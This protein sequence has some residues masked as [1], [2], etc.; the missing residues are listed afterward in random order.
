VQLAGDVDVRFERERGVEHGL[1]LFQ[2]DR[3]DRLVDAVRVRGGLL[4]DV[5][6]RHVVEAREQLVVLGEVGVAEHVRGHQRVLGERVAVHQ[7]RAA[8]VAR[9]H[10][11]EDLRVP[12]LWRTSWW[13]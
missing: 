1:D 7:E 9:E 11:L 13:M 12:M 8:R 5:A 4:D 10:D 6:A 2:P 3:L